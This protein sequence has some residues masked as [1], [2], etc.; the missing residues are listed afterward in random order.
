VYKLWSNPRS[1]G[2]AGRQKN[3]SKLICDAIVAYLT[4]DEEPDTAKQ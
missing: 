4:G 2:F 1:S 3:K